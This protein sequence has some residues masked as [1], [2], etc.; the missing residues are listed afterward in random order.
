MD[1]RVGEME[2]RRPNACAMYIILFFLY[3]CY[4]FITFIAVFAYMRSMKVSDKKKQ[5]S[6]VSFD[7]GI[8]MCV[9]AFGSLFLLAL[10]CCVAFSREIKKSQK[11]VPIEIEEP[12]PVNQ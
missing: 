10:A 12:A 7:V 9:I 6:S 3:L 1:N 8:F 11:I 2:E 5:E 4:L